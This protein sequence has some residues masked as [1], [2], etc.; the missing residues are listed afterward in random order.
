MTSATN[1]AEAEAVALDHL[2]AVQVSLRVLRRVTGLRIALVARVTESSWSACA[3]LDDAG[4][5]IK[6]G[7]E[8]ELSTTY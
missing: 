5:G 2:D 3:V 7:D 8:Y 6:T 1:Q 4:F